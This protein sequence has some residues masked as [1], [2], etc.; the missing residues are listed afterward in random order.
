MARR[1]F[2]DSATGQIHE[3]DVDEAGNETP[4]VAPAS[5]ADGTK[6][7][8][9]A[10]QVPYKVPGKQ[11]I[12]DQPSVGEL[13]T[14]KAVSPGIPGSS[15]LPDPRNIKQNLTTAGSMAAG[16]VGGPAGFAASIGRGALGAMLGNVAGQGAEMTQNDKDFSLGEM[17]DAGGEDAFYSTVLGKA[18]RI[19]GPLIKNIGRGK[20]AAG[21]SRAGKAIAAKLMSW[22]GETDSAGNRIDP[23]TPEIRAAL[24]GPE[25]KK[26]PFTSGMLLG[27]RYPEELLAP[28][29]SAKATE[30]AQ[31]ANLETVQKYLP[32]GSTAQTG[33]SGVASS[34]AVRKSLGNVEKQAYGEIK[35]LAEKTVVDIPLPP[36]TISTGVLDAKGN[37]ITRVEPQ[38]VKIVGPINVGEVKTFANE[39]LKDLQESLNLVS[40][41]PTLSAKMKSLVS[42]L[43]TFSNTNVISYKQAD[44]TRATLNKILQ[45]QDSG[46]LKGNPERLISELKSKLDLD[47]IASMDM[48][49]WPA[50]SS[51]AYRAAMEATRQ[52][53][54]IITKA[55]NK[56]V[57]AARA[58]PEKFFQGAFNDATTARETAQVA[59]LEPT[60]KEYVRQFIDPF[61]NKGTGAFEGGAAMEAWTKTANSEVAGALLTKNQREGI[62]QF[63]RRASVISGDA[64]NV[65]TIKNR[66]IATSVGS[67]RDFTNAIGSPG[68][69]F[70]NA[71]LKISVRLGGKQFAEKV[72]LNPATARKAARLLTMKGT[73]PEAHSEARNFILG[74]NLG[75][76]VLRAGNGEEVLYDTETGEASKIK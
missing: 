49:K 25:A 56:R 52:R 35:N 44:S 29:L 21:N 24:S 42:T 2:K 73:R 28:G 41:S 30:A 68:K 19:L 38:S 3:V 72:L 76:I 18:G 63:F 70:T 69:L 23:F 4:I 65:L 6:V 60:Q 27:N 16:M 5:I 46:L 8:F 48:G 12:L 43:E 67:A 55:V 10:P 54:A 14:F 13:G 51:D 66:D 62:E 45:D 74:G 31:A 36:K 57:K 32:S 22:M 47:I 61:L 17:A 26:I 34:T 75:E 20:D 59:G 1:K 64:G 9:E 53:G 71:A 39:N 40:G 58:V 33:A 37:P 50:G 7:K 11:A 15:I